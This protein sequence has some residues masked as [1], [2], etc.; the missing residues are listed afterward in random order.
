MAVG[1]CFQPVCVKRP[2]NVMAGGISRC[3]RRHINT[4]LDPVF[5][6]CSM[7]RNHCGGDWRDGVFRDLSIVL[8]KVGIALSTNANS[9]PARKMWMKR[10]QDTVKITVYFDA[11][12][13]EQLVAEVIS[14]NFVYINFSR[15]E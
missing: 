12:L 15:S 5:S 9:P 1:W 13:G 14:N 6:F 2:E 3:P 7:A 8:S 11:S 4:K 10:R